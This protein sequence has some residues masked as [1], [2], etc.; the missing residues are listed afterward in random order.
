MLFNADF[1]PMLFEISNRS[2]YMWMK[3]IPAFSQQSLL[4]AEVYLLDAWNN[5]YLWVGNESN[6]HERNG[7]YKRAAAYIDCLKDGRDKE[8][9]HII[10]IRPTQEPQMFKVQFPNW[11]DHYSQSWLTKDM[12]AQ[13]QKEHGSGGNVASSGATSAAS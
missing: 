7:G 4:N 13:M 12:L 5:F 11:S 9:I 8:K 1:E 3:Q 10:E 2:G 6:K